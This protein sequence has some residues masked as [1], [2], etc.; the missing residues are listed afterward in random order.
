MTTEYAVIDIDGTSYIVRADG[1]G[2]AVDLAGLREDG[3]DVEDRCGIE[4]PRHMQGD[5]SGDAQAWLTERAIAAGLT[6]IQTSP[7]YGHRIAR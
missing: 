3:A 2:S 4:L 7:E 5:A 1:P 6:V